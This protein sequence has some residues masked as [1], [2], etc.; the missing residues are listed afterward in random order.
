MLATPWLTSPVSVVCLLRW[1]KWTGNFVTMGV[2]P[3][4]DRI[5]VPALALK[6]YMIA[7]EERA[8]P[9][10]S[11]FIASRA[12]QSRKCPTPDFTNALAPKSRL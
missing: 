10:G 7:S 5:Y 8:I 2:T 6:N 4:E 12:L 3:S 1:K 9:A 11:P